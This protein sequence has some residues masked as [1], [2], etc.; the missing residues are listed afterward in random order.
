MRECVRKHSRLPQTVVVDNGKEFGSI[1]FETLLAYFEITKKSRPPAKS[2]FG[3]VIERMFGTT[4]TM[5]VHNLKGNTLIMKEVRLVTKSVNPKQHAIWTI[6]DLNDG[7]NDWF[8]EV[9]HK[10][11]HPALGQTPL[12]CFEQS[13][14]ISGLRK[15]KLIRYDDEFK[16]LTLPSTSKGVGKVHIGRGVKIEYKYYWCSEF[17]NPKIEKYECGY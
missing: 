11:P 15:S 8:E 14:M 2:R 9:Y 13:L 4:N 3:S 16:I 17:S 5:F 6:K 1:Y 12:E 7:L 10:L